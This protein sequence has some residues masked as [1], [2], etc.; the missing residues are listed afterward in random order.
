MKAALAV[1]LAAVLCAQPA[2]S[3]WCFTCEKQASNWT[4]LKFTKCAAA[5]RHCLTIV[6]NTGLG[7]WTVNRQITKKCSPICPQMNINLGIASFTTACCQHSLCNVGGKPALKP[8][9]Q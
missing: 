1:L 7:I 4:C 3:L 9:A 6:R 8:A 5:D 2:A